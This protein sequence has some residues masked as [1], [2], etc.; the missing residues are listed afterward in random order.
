[1]SGS[2]YN[3]IINLE[4]NANAGLVTVQNTVS[5]TNTAFGSLFNQIKKVGEGSFFLNQLNQSISDVRRKFNDSTQD[6]EE[7]QASIAELSAI[8]GVTGQGLDSIADKARI[9][10]KAF[11]NDGSKA[12]TAYKL[13]LSQLSPDLAKTPEA[14]DMMGRSVS[15]LSKQMSNDPVAASSVLTAAMNQFGVS[16]ENPIAAA[17]TMNRMMNV[18]ATAAKEGSAELP[19][20]KLALEQCGMAAN[21][22]NVSFEET[23]AAVQVLDKLGKRGAEGGVA[24]RN[25]LSIMAEGRF[26]P[27]ET[28]LALQ[29]AGVDINKLGDKSLSLSQR[30]TELAKVKNDDAL[31]TKIFGK[32]NYQAGIALT[33]NIDLLEEYRHKITGTNTA[34]EQAA[35]IMATFRERM[36]HINAVFS[37]WKISMFNIAEP[38]LPFV[39]VMGKGVDALVTTGQAMNG[40]SLIADTKLGAKIKGATKSVFEFIRSINL[41]N[42]ALRMST[43]VQSLWGTITSLV[44]GKINAASLATKALSLSMRAIPILAIATA[45]SYGIAKFVQYRS[46]V[47]EARRKETEAQKTAQESFAKERMDLDLLFDR[48]RRT[49]PK[50]KERI[51]LV[52]SLKE[53]YPGLNAQLVK[54]LETTNNLKGAYD[55]LIG[56]IDKKIKKEALSSITTD[57]VK[58]MSIIE[59]INKEKIS[60]LIGESVAIGGGARGGGNIAKLTNESDVTKR[61][62][63]VF[64]TGNRQGTH[65]QELYE[66]GKNIAT[67]SNKQKKYQEK[68]AQ[69]SQLDLGGTVAEAKTL[70][71][72]ASGASETDKESLNTISGG[73]TRSTNINI[74]LDSLIDKF[75][76]KP[77]TIKESTGEIKDMIVQTLLQALNSGNALAIKSN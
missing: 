32:E 30:L 23:N 51:E 19:A 60:A 25:M 27:K 50:S 29:A 46:A 42:I 44:T 4:G 48:L 57:M 39:N 7:F 54:E 63:D 15:V 76:I 66:I 9:T 69:I 5:K 14:L 62:I 13:L 77:Q 45:L 38:V 55:D 59:D 74:Q 16:M 72:G 37:D 52:K 35:T 53:Q 18:M 43:A 40:F 61:A 22:A 73:G 31:M 1:M 20:I 21:T 10:A 71:K 3:I 17:R 68:V 2:I 36:A 70:G 64:N 65:G 24:L 26:I 56:S 34:N 8:T 47:N 12:V 33:N 75:E 11:N 6:G 28:R 41:K 49:N 67:L 58:E